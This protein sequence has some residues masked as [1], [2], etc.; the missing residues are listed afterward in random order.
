M[1]GCSSNGPYRGEKRKMDVQLRIVKA[2][3][4][5]KKAKV[6]FNTVTNELIEVEAEN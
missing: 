5:D 6:K 4:M 2:I 3:K 1:A